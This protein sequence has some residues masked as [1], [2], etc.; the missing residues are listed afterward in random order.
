M[1]D[2]APE[3]SKQARLLGLVIAA[4]IV[5]SDQLSKPFLLDLM[6]KNPGGIEVTPFFNLVMVWNR[7][8]SFGMFSGAGDERRWIL[9]AAAAAVTVW[10]LIWL[11]RGPARLVTVALG[12][13]VGGA[14][15]NIGDRLR[16]GAV[17]DF[18]DFHAF[19][20]HWPAFNIA[21]CA[22]VVGVCLLL[23]DS[24]L[25]RPNGQS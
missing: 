15:G 14:L 8:V 12:L 2:Q 11:W 1:P 3:K 9:I 22:I 23:L 21:D 24:L 10:L 19:G 6:E 5:I 4:L 25:P 20:W 13:V 17:A 7:G 16:F 18:F